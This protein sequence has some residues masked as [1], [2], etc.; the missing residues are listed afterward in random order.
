MFHFF[1]ELTEGFNKKDIFNNISTKVSKLK[2]KLVSAT[3][4]NA[5]IEGNGISLNLK[6]LFNKKDYETFNS[7][8]KDLI[9]ALDTIIPI[10]VLLS[11]ILS[12]SWTRIIK[13]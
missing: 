5:G 11:N 9:K 6:E 8:K 10:T 3:T 2:N 7:I 12:N 13:C 1:D 4:I